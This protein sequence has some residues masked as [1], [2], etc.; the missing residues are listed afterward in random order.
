[1]S[2]HEKASP[3]VNAG[4]DPK[5]PLEPSRALVPRVSGRVVAELTTSSDQPCP[6]PTVE[7]LAPAVGP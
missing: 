3:H 5:S 7:R 6:V 1:M 4:F 2:G